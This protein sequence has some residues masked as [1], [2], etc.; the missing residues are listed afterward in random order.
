MARVWITDGSVP[1]FSDTVKLD[2][3]HRGV[4]GLPI[5]YEGFVDPDV[6][7][8]AGSV[9][10]S[11]PD[12]R[13]FAEAEWYVEFVD[14]IERYLDGD[15]GV[16]PSTPVVLQGF[17]EGKWMNRLLGTEAWQPASLGNNVIAD[18]AGI[19]TTLGALAEGSVGET[20]V[21]YRLRDGTER[22]QVTRGSDLRGHGIVELVGAV[23]RRCREN[24]Q[25]VDGI[26]LG[27]LGE[28]AAIV[29]ERARVRRA[30]RADRLPLPDP[31]NLAPHRAKERLVGRALADEL[32]VPPGGVVQLVTHGPDGAIVGR[33]SLE[34]EAPR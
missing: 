25:A 6:P 27:A 29:N 9:R 11:G 22:V 15:V 24:G 20:R 5:R 23:L 10:A 32:H 28:A 2:V 26:D 7:R 1:V 3:S 34:L 19:P 30:L 21:T 31:R 13:L 4:L 18:G 16:D 12:D 8:G 33:G 14:G 17:L